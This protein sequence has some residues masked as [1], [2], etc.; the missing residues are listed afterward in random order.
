MTTSALQASFLLYFIVTYL[1]WPTYIGW[2]VRE[3]MNCIAVT[4]IP[5]P[6]FAQTIGW[7][8]WNGLYFCAL[9]TL[10]ASSVSV[11]INTCVMDTK[12]DSMGGALKKLKAIR[13]LWICLKIS[14]WTCLSGVEWMMG[15]GSGG[16]GA[17][18]PPCN[19]IFELVHSRVGSFNRP[20]ALGG[21]EIIIFRDA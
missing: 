21:P 16:G 20:W 4:I 7:P 10:C 19:H 18:W 5:L 1:C 2:F 8:A 13:E 12:L 11:H 14:C 15:E 3:R 6:M 17:T 9:V